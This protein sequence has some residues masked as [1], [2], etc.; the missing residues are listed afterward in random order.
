[1][2]VG[3]GQRAVDARPSL[4]PSPARRRGWWCRG[5]ASAI[6]PSALSATRWMPKKLRSASPRFIADGSSASV[7]AATR[8]E[9][10][11]AATACRAAAE[12]GTPKPTSM[13]AAQDT[14]VA[15]VDDAG[16]DAARRSAAWRA[17][18][19]TAI[20]ERARALPCA[21][22]RASDARPAGHGQDQQQR[23]LLDGIEDLRRDDRREHAA[24]H[25]AERHPQIEFGQVRGSPG[26]ARRARDGRPSS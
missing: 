4:D 20:S 19:A 26:G 7:S 10:E 5:A 14:A 18:P 15:E 8:D 9:D 23:E 13:T 25:A 24:E 1:M 22:R 12:R 16:S 2:I 11:L 17:A 3:R 6:V 21:S